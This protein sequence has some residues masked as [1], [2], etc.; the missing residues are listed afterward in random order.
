VDETQTLKKSEIV[1]GSEKSS[2]K[3]TRDGEPDNESEAV[4]DTEQRYVK[5]SLKV[6]ITE[7]MTGIRDCLSAERHKTTESP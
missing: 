7:T 5:E 2:S 3:C 6:A 4:K 1:L